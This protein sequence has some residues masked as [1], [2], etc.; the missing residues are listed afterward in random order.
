MK[1]IIHREYGEPGVLQLEDLP[2]PTP[3]MN[4]VL[5]KVHAIGMNPPDWKLRRQ[6]YD[7]WQ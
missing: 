1:A 3:S 4:Q 2:D 6:A 5:V 7:G